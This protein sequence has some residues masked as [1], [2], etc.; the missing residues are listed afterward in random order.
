MVSNKSSTVLVEALPHCK[1]V[2]EWHFW[3]LELV[4][5]NLENSLFYYFLYYYLCKSFLTCVVP[6][7][8]LEAINNLC[9]PSWLLHSYANL[10]CSCYDQHWSSIYCC[11]NGDK[12]CFRFCNNSW[13]WLE[14]KNCSNVT[15]CN[16]YCDNWNDILTDSCIKQK[17]TE[18]KCK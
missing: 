13:E 5:G 1:V 14:C 16:D 11:Y 9:I 3:H 4:N 7:T 12:M 17:N 15:I 10:Q 2:S 6:D 8:T 18:N